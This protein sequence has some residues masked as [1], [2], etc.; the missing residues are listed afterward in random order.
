MLWHRGISNEAAHTVAAVGG[1]SAAYTNFAART[2]GLDSTHLTAYATLLNGLTTDGF[3]DGSGNSTLLDFFYIFAT[4]D[5]TTALLN[6]VSANYNATAVSSPTFTADTGYDFS[7][8]TSHLTTNFNPATA[9][10]PNFVRN[11]AHLWVWANL[12]STTQTGAIGTASEK[13]AVYARSGGSTCYFQINDQNYSTLVAN[14]ATSGLF[15]A[16]RISSTDEKGYV[17][18]VQ[19]ATSSSTSLAVESTN[20]LIVNAATWNGKQMGAGGGAG[21]TTGQITAL[22]SRVHTYLQTIAGVP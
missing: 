8:S 22:Y 7:P 3:F 2:S 5:A 13:T 11:S 20:I 1:N 19:K 12:C 14:S 17:D 16:N 21:L 6:L 18:A 10:S 15:L 4:A 9:T